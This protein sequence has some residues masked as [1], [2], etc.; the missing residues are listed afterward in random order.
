LSLKKK[1]KKEVMM[2]VKEE[3]EDDPLLLSFSL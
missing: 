2:E 1:E 3:Y